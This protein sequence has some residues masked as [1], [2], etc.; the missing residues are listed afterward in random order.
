MSLISISFV[1]FLPV[2]ALVHFMLP[3]KWRYIWIFLASCFFYLSNNIRYAGAL[4]F[5]TATTYAAGLAMKRGGRRKAYLAVGI[6]LNVA[7]LFLFRHLSPRSGFVPAGI[8]F[9]MLQAIGYLVDVYRGD[10]EAEGNPVRYAAFVSFFPTVQSGPIQRGTGLLRQLREGTDF[11]DSKAHAGLY[12]LLW[13]YLLK[14]V[15]ADRLDPM[16]GFAY[17][18]YETMPGAVMLWATILYAVQLYCDFAGYSALAVG[19]GKMMGFDL[20]ENF[21]QPYF[22]S[23]IKAFWSRWHI[24]LSSWLKDYVY[25]PLGGNRKGKCRKCWNLMATFLVSG[26][27]HGKGLQFLAWGALHGLYQAVWDLSSRK[28][29]EKKGFLR[30]I[31]GVIITFALVDF[32]WIFFRADSVGQAVCIAES[33]LLR[34]RLKEMTYYGYYLLGMESKRNLV[35]LLLGIT[36]V[37]LID[38][39]HEKKVSIER[40]AGRLHAGIR[41]LLYAALTM[42][43]LFVAVRCYGQAASTFIY[44]RF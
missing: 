27:W 36:G 5:C 25:I 10:V 7:A 20:G 32:A 6:V 33:I 4:L 8:S 44:G 41:W 17:D 30:K 38:F 16:V 43:V 3:R 12:C 35:L 11:D 19:A 31:A 40:A 37:F 29:G 2:A 26:L 14:F 28:G 39:A 23:S 13:G 42:L 15:I 22:A 9:Y 21:A 1:V 18:R 24:S 34:F